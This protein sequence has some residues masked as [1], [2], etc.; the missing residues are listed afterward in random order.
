MQHR[1]MD[2]NTIYNYTKTQ[3]GVIE[4]I[5]HV[6]KNPTQHR[7]IFT[8]RN[9]KINVLFLLYSHTLINFDIYNRINSTIKYINS[10]YK[11]QP[12]AQKNDDI[13]YFLFPL[14]FYEVIITNWNKTTCCWWWPLLLVLFSSPSFGVVVYDARALVLVFYLE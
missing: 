4:L 1:H 9:T 12:N 2:T 5:T 7:F 8:D 11:S 6:R 10:G 3:H 13:F 14:N